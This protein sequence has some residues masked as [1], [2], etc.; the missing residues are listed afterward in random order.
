MMAL[1]TEQAQ[2]DFGEKSNFGASGQHIANFCSSSVALP[3][4]THV[5]QQNQPFLWP[6]ILGPPD[7]GEKPGGK[8]TEKW[9]H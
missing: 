9:N 2:A 8:D 6:E 3:K 5:W 7:E 1:E 4:R